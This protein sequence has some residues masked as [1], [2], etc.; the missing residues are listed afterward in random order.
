MDWVALDP[1]GYPG[2][3][4]HRGGEVQNRNGH[5]MAI[6]ARGPKR[7]V[8]LTTATGRHA[9][10]LGALVLEVFG[11][12]R[13]TGVPVRRDGCAGHLGDD[14]LLPSTT[15]AWLAS[16]PS[17]VVPR[18]LGPAS[19]TAMASAA[20]DRPVAR[21]S[22]L[23]QLQQVYASVEDASI[24]SRTP[25]SHIVQACEGLAGGPGRSGLWR[26]LAA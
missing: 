5:F 9:V 8:V 12:Q 20:S 18:S 17:A 24:R 22:A 10:E 7:W 2:Y 16:A 14:N 3:R 19:G 23:G 25:R 11:G 13:S 4:L 21:F 6:E 26:Y 1:H 15:G